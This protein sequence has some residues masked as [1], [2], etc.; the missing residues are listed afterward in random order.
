M[1]AAALF[2]RP[3][4]FDCRRLQAGAATGDYW[5]L[6]APL[7]PPS[8]A[9]PPAL[10]ERAASVRTASVWQDR[11]TLYVRYADGA[12]RRAG[13]TSA[14]TA[15]HL[16]LGAIFI[17]AW[18]LPIVLAGVR[19]LASAGLIEW[20][21]WIDNSTV[22]SM[23]LEACLSA[24]AIAGRIRQLASE[25]DEARE[26]EVAARLLADTDPLTGLLNRRAFLHRGDRPRGR[27][28]A[29]PGRRRSF[30]AGQRHHRP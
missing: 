4:Q 26:Q 20:R 7:P 23:A 30:Q 6:S 8:P 24:L 1:T 19:V 22:P 15:P 11:V 21:F 27:S 28:G 14:T 2:A 18:G 13:F 10:R 25:R 12:I 9:P 29:D 5:V 3:R 17:L 16:V